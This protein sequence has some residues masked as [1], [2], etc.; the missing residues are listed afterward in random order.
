MLVAGFNLLEPPSA[1]LGLS[2]VLADELFLSVALGAF[3]GALDLGAI[4]K[5][6]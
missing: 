1:L 5:N 2:E 3:A 4:S 6:S